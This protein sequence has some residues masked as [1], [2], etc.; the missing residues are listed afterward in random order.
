MYSDDKMAP[1]EVGTTASYQCNKGF[2]LDGGDF[3][4][5]CVVNSTSLTGY[6][7]GTARHCLGTLNVVNDFLLGT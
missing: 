1:F 6:W 3:V 5:F 4:R 7:N 2:V